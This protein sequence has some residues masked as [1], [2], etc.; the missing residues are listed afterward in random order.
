MYFIVVMCGNAH[1]GTLNMIVMSGDEVELEMTIQPSG[2][3]IP[4][5]TPCLAIPFS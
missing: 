1:C 3:M 5:P 2:N 4:T